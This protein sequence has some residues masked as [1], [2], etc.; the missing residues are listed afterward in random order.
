MDPGT[1]TGLSKL[2]HPDI[3]RR[4]F[5]PRAERGVYSPDKSSIDVQI[6]VD[7]TVSIGARF[8]L[9]SKDA[10]N[11][12]FFH[13]NGE[14]V[15]DYDELAPFYNRGGLNFLPVEYRGYGLS[16]GSP[17]VTAMMH[18]AHRIYRYVESWLENEQYTGRLVVMGR[19]LGSASAIELASRYS[20]RIDGLIVESGFAHTAPL[21]RLLG[22]D[23]ERFGIDES[24]D[25]GNLERWGTTAIRCWSFTR[26]RTIS[27]RYRT[28]RRYMMPA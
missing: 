28:V 14:I 23:I 10:P 15:A 18:D 22:I 12:L 3:L 13:G 19:S 7:E 4:L 5:H 25:I 24:D 27:S 20:E 16:G 11:I 9:I 17:T 2:D 26:C 1:F 21:L 6:P 8:H